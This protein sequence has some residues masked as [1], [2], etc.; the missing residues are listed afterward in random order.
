M[1]VLTLKPLILLP[2]GSP[3]SASETS[4]LVCS[5]YD[6]YVEIFNEQ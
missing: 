2:L 3:G 1:L 5:S 6:K 4:G